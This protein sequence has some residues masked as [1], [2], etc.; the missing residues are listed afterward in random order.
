M[1]NQLELSIFYA[2]KALKVGDQLHMTRKDKYPDY[3][4][5]IAP[6]QYNL[7]N[8]LTTYAELNLNE[9]GHL[10]PL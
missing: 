3:Q 8:A 7:A 5:I 9:M 6:L 10:N 2:K 4:I 1:V